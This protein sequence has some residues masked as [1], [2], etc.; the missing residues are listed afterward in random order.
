MAADDVWICPESALPKRIADYDDIGLAGLPIFGG[1][2]S[3]FNC[4]HTKHRKQVGGGNL[5]WNLF[6]FA[7]AG[8][9]STQVE[10]SGHVFKNVILLFPIKKVAQ[11]DYVLIVALIAIVFPHH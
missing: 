3:T 11:V 2:G 7:V 5:S 8:K 10:E 1:K 4:I 6:G 9:F